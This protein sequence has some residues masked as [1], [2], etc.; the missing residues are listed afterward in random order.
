MTNLLEIKHLNISFEIHGKKLEAIRD[1]SFKLR[2]GETLA[3]VGES[4]SGKSVTTKAITRLLAE[5]AHIDSGEIFLDGK[6]LLQLNM[7]EMDAV[8]GSDISMIFQ[9]PMTAL[10]PTMTIGRQVERA[11]AQH[12]RLDTRLG[13]TRLRDEAIDLLDKVGIPNP[14]SRL[15]N[16]PHQLSGG[17]LQ[18]VVIAIALAGNPRI[19]IAD[20]PT[21]ALD[22]TIQ[23]QI[24][25]LLNSL[26]AKLNMSIIFIT[27]DLGVVAEIADRVA[28]MYAGKIVEY[29]SLNDIFYNPKHP[30]TWA[31]LSAMPTTETNG[32]ELFTIPGNPPKIGQFPIGD[33]FAQRNQY[34]TKKD[35]EEQP[36]FFE[37]S[38]GHQ[39]ATWLL[40]KDAAP[41][42]PPK[43]ILKRAA[44]YQAYQQDK[45]KGV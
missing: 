7:K 43:E 25:A 22:V 41:V 4:G 9:D 15:K 34:A 2:S 18:R 10:D 14:S 23:A 11:V 42:T 12:T 1:V 35:Y 27:H 44:I 33:A 20:E 30:Y 29:G 37:V 24:I 32:E 8:R 39:A 31:L 21:T 28:V 36:P 26:K 38:P 3:L 40:D 17:L 16:Y 45:E 13:K 6:D 5:N 19:L